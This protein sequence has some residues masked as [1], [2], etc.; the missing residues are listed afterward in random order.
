MEYL[1]ILSVSY[2][3]IGAIFLLQG[4]FN[5]A[6]KTRVSFASSIVQYWLIRLPMAA[7]VGLAFDY[8]VLA[9]FWAITLSNVVVAL[10]LAAY[11]LYA[12]SS[13]LMDHVSEE[14]NASNAG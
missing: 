10:G 4:G 11:F 12:D 7:A 13:G 8:D 1:R 5:G 9:V 2:P 6:K 3:A 14:I